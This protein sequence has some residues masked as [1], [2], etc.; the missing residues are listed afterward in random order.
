MELGQ[1]VYEL[2]LLLND[3]LPA[4]ERGTHAVRVHLWA[5]A[6]GGIRIAEVDVSACLTAEAKGKG[7]IAAGSSYFRRDAIEDPCHRTAQLFL[8]MEEFLVM[9]AFGTDTGDDLA[10]IVAIIIDRWTE[11]PA[12]GPAAAATTGIAGDRCCH[13]NECGRLG[14]EDCQQ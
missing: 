13:G 2:E 7:I 9:K 10:P 11:T 6:Y 12:P 5:P 14:C 1:A 4:S 8:A 3:S